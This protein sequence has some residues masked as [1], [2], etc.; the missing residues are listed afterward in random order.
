MPPMPPRRPRRNS[1]LPRAATVVVVVESEA[2]ASVTSY[3]AV[4]ACVC[5]PPDR[6]PNGGYPTDVESLRLRLEGS[7]PLREVDGIDK[8]G[9]TLCLPTLGRSTMKSALKAFAGV[10]EEE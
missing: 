6:R 9:T 8:I 3:E 4:T 1:S 5:V 2:E 7:V 10:G